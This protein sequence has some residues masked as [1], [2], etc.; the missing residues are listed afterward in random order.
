MARRVGPFVLIL[1]EDSGRLWLTLTPDG[2][3]PE[4]VFDVVG[5]TVHPDDP[6]LDGFADIEH[7]DLEAPGDLLLDLESRGQALI[8]DF[9][10]LVPYEGRRPPGVPA[11]LDPSTTG[12]VAQ[13]DPL[14]PNVPAPTGGNVP[15]P[16]GPPAPTGGNPPAPTGGTVPVP[17]GP[18]APTGGNVPIPPGPPALPPPAVPSPN[19]TPTG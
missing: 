4:T 9:D 1:T 3:A 7:L 11:P 14:P 8:V 2:G 13:N 18:P 6:D 12:P 17:P 15:V 16:P 5:P 19:Q 10:D